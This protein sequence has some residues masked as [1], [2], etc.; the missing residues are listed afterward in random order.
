LR[1][2]SLEDALEVLDGDTRVGIGVVD[3]DSQSVV[4]DGDGSRQVFTVL[5]VL[6]LL[7][8]KVARSECQPSL[9]VH[10]FLDGILFVGVLGFK[11]V[12][13]AVVAEDVE[14][15]V[16]DGAETFVGYEISGSFLIVL[17]RLCIFRLVPT[18]EEQA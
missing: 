3:D 11:G 15:F 18:S 14:G 12:K 13:Y 16:E 4:C 1:N 10:Q 6:A 2:L 9:Q 8:G 17:L 7:L 5:E